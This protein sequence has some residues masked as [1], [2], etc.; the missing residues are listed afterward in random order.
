MDYYVRLNN[1]CPSYVLIV[2][3]LYHFLMIIM[4]TLYLQRGKVGSD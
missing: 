3:F 1:T 4:H 2:I